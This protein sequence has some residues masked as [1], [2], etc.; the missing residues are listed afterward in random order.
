VVIE[1]TG[2]FSEKSHATRTTRRTYVFGSRS[3]LT[4]REKGKV[5]PASKRPAQKR[6]Q[7]GMYKD[8]WSKRLVRKR[9]RGV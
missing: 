1:G 8:F 4:K 3:R 2:F 7:R 9:T 6:S 5:R